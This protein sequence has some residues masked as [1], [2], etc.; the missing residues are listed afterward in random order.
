[1]PYQWIGQPGLPTLPIAPGSAPSTLKFNLT[2]LNTAFKCY[3]RFSQVL[4]RVAILS[5]VLALNDLLLN[6]RISFLIG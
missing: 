1:M 3:R 6:P 4:I 2:S 5:F